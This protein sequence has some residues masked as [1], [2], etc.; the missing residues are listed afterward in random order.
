MADLFDIL[1]KSIDDIADLPSFKAPDTGMYRLSITFDT[2]E[3]N[4][5]PAVVAR[6][7]VRELLALADD[8]IPENERAKPGDKFDVPHILKDEDGKD[9]EFAWGMLKAL[10]KP[11]EIHFG[12]TNLK[13]L[14]KK[15]ATEGG[16]SVDITAKVVKKQRK[17]DKDKFSARVEEIVIE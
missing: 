14:I 10:I 3:I 2:K 15:M 13:T 9:S 17:D 1:D 7:V 4:K 12:E 5:K 16:E 8:A 6:F 11:F